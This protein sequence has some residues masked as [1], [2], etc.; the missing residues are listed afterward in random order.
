MKSHVLED[1]GES[2]YLNILKKQ[3]RELDISYVNTHYGKK[4]IEE[5][6]VY[7]ILKEI[8][9]RIDDIMN[10]IKTNEDPDEAVDMLDNLYESI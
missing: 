10:D 6:I 2:H 9:Q 3:S 7:N 8:E 4:V 5:S 1:S